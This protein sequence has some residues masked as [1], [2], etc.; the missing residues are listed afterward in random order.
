MNYPI[1]GRNDIL[2]IENNM[3]KH[4]IDDERKKLDDYID[5]E[6]YITK[7]VFQHIIQE[8]MIS[9]TITEENYI[10]DK[11]DFYIGEIIY[12]TYEK[13]VIDSEEYEFIKKLN[14]TDHLYYNHSV[15]GKVIKIQNTENSLSKLTLEISTKE[16]IR[17]IIEDEIKINYHKKKMLKKVIEDLTNN[18]FITLSNEEYKSFYNNKTKVLCNLIDDK[19]C[20]Y[21][22]KLEVYG[23]K[24]DKKGNTLK[25]DMTPDKRFTYWTPVIQ[26]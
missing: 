6:K 25:H 12:A 15:K 7:L 1:Q 23:K 16:I 22:F 24:K 4:N 26:K 19:K 11:N 3:I 2:I 21:T 17:S 10:K 5:Y 9:N 8:I 14:V 20:Q 18:L 13:E